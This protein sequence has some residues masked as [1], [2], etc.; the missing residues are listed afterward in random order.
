MIS[1][2][3]I[4]SGDSIFFLFSRYSDHVHVCDTT[5]CFESQYDVQPTYQWTV[6]YRKKA[7]IQNVH[8]GYAYVSIFLSQFLLSLF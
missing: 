6:F 2:P 4:Q 1:S 8:V 7:G 3:D 5:D